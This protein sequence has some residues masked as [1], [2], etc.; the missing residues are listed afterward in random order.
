VANKKADSGYPGCCLHPPSDIGKLF[1]TLDKE[2]ASDIL[3]EILEEKESW[4][5]KP[6]KGRDV[7]EIGCN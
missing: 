5:F 2:R 1:L 6:Y 7:F 3:R 4:E